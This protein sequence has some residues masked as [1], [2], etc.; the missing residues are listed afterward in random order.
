MIHLRLRAFASAA[1]TAC[2]AGLLVATTVAAA[3][4]K[5][6]VKVTLPPQWAHGKPGILT[7]VGVA[8]PKAPYTSE[9]VVYG[10]RLDCPRSGW[11][12]LGRKDPSAQGYIIGAGVSSTYRVVSARDTPPPADVHTICA[13]L[14]TVTTHATIARQAIHWK[15]RSH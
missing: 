4:G 7:I 15:Q 14:M 11:A 13:Y 3:S 12:F 8:P 5:Y 2:A 10:T 1:L 6:S 9:L